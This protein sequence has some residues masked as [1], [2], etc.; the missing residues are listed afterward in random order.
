MRRAPSTNHVTSPPQFSVQ[1]MPPFV[2]PF[3]AGGDTPNG[4]GSTEALP[5]KM[6]SLPE[7]MAIR[8]RYGD[9]NIASAY[10]RAA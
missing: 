2:S 9:E 1:R 6:S 3:S 5:K 10:L 8:G 4:Y 7:A